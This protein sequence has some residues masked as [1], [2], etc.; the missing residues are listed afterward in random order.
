[1]HGQPSIKIMRY[2]IGFEKRFI[3]IPSKSYRNDQQDATVWDNLLF[4][5]SLTAQ[6]VS[7]DIIPHRHELLNCKYSFWFYS[8]LS[9]PAAVMSEWE[10]L[11]MSDNIARNMLSSQGT[12]E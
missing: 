6:Y 7:S 2:F 9:L 10:L 5:C 11:M 12:M 8:R 4:H 1:M 3:Q